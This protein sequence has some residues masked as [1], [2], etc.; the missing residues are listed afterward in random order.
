MR[1]K[2]KINLDN[3]GGFEGSKINLKYPNVA[4]IITIAH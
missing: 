2:S 1:F 4:I 3:F